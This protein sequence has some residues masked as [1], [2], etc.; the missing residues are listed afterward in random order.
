MKSTWYK[1]IWKTILQ[2]KILSQPEKESRKEGNEGQ[3][4][5]KLRQIYLLCRLS[6]EC[7]VLFANI[8]KMLKCWTRLLLVGWVAGRRDPDSSKN[9]SGLKLNGSP[10]SSL[11]LM[12]HKFM[13]I[14]L[15]LYIVLNYVK[16]YLKNQNLHFFANF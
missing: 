5:M 13:R 11:W 14:C 3:N 4:W 6:K 16:R 15:N 8:S 2:N 12:V 9:R 7:R 1:N 10:Q